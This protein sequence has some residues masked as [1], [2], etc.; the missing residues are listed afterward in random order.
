M[1]K[2]IKQEIKIP[3]ILNGG[4]SSWE[5][6]QEALQFSGCDGV[7]S[8][9]A[10]LEYPALFNGPDLIDMDKLVLEYFDMYEK[11]TGEA[12]PIIAKAHLH[13]FLHA[14]F[15]LQKHT[16]LRE[17]LNAII[18]KEGDA[19]KKMRNV[20]EEMAERRKDVP[21][22][23][24]ITWYYRHWKES[25]SHVHGLQVKADL[26]SAH[27]TDAEWEEWMLDDPRNPMSQK[28]KDAKA[29]EK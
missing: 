17:K 25:E 22:I 27:I 15:V 20:A 29:E 16:D 2:R 23:Q 21:I 10:I 24:K 18:F 19:A 3:V 7:M 26:P 4:I 13:K 6:V 8:S 1:I 5:D 12:N 11:Y 14:G 28:V 9:E